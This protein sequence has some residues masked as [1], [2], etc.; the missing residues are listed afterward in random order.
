MICMPLILQ[1]LPMFRG[2]QVEVKDGCVIGKK[3]PEVLHEAK[4]DIYP[5][6]T[7]LLEI[8]LDSQSK[9]QLKT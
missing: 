3:C 5:N 7:K 8:R 4:V 2:F 6:Q 1:Y 9:P